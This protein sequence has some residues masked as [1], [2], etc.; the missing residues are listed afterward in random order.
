MEWFIEVSNGYVCYPRFPLSYMGAL[1]NVY[2]RWHSVSAASRGG[3]KVPSH[4]I[5]GEKYNY[6]PL[7]F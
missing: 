6:S 4:L 7:V 2:Q 1:I 5:G 3:A